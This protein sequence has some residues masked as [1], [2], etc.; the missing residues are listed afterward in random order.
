MR[1]EDVRCD[2]QLVR[3]RFWGQVPCI[4]PARPVHQIISMIK[5]IRT[6]RLST[7]NSI[8][9][10]PHKGTSKLLSREK[11]EAS[12]FAPELSPAVIA[13]HITSLFF[14]ALKPGVER[15]TKSMSLNY[16]PASVP[17][18]IYVK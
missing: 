15:Y 13:L 18:H 2:Q 8:S 3:R 14:I 4:I 17:L 1:R 16:E 9:L 6:S 12:C 11:A 7:K 10:Y 5:W